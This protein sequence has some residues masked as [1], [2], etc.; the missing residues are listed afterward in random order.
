MRI[1]DLSQSLLEGKQHP[2]IVVDVQP[3]YASYAGKVSQRIIDFVAQQTG[4]VLMF[5]NAEDTGVTE[6][7]MVDIRM[8]WDEYADIDWSRV[9]MVDKGYGYFR[10]WMDNGVDPASIIRVVRAMYQQRVSSS[11]QL[12][13]GVGSEEYPLHMQQLVGDEYEEW[14]NDDPISI[15]WANVAQLRKFN[16]AYL[17][18]GGRNEC[19]REV[20]L[21]MNAF[22]IRYKR[23]A[24]MVY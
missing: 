10:S 20:E 11:D 3:A 2:V 14:M 6:D 21:L 8:W 12:F 15:Y 18:G 16:G 4:P 22:N 5:V 17:V 9:Q 7:S 1:S 24:S 13:D 19:L 23:I